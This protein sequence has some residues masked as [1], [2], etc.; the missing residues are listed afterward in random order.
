MEVH[1]D[2][3]RRVDKK[4]G[5]SKEVVSVAVSGPGLAKEK[6][7]GDIQL[8]SGTG[9]KI[10]QAVFDKLLLWRIDKLV[11]ALSYDTCSVNTGKHMGKPMFIYIYVM[12]CSVPMNCDFPAKFVC[13]KYY[14]YFF[15]VTLL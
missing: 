12:R 8:D 9:K 10:A 5:L 15:P 7:L 14:I 2:G 6:F 4:T 1:F 13:F 3:K 11:V